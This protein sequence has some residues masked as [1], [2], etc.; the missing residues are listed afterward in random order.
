[1]IL[2][3]V[4]HGFFLGLTAVIPYDNLYVLNQRVGLLRKKNNINVYF[5][6]AL[7]NHN[8]KYFASVGQ[9]TSQKNL[10]KKDILDFQTRIPNDIKEQE[11]IGEFF[12]KID[13]ILEFSQKKITKLEN[14]KK[15]L[16]NKMFV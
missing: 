5:L 6:S 12:R 14:I 8:Q 7:I 11:K 2:S 10:S 15:Y 13:G 4:A 3:D 1:M 9:G 16:L